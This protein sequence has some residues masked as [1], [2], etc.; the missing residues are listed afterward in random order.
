MATVNE[1]I[2]EWIK[3]L[4]KQWLTPVNQKWGFGLRF[5]CAFA[6][7]LSVFT[8]VA[9]FRLADTMGILVTDI[10]LTGDFYYFSIIFIALLIS[11]SV[12]IWF[13]WL[14]SWRDFGYGPARLYL[15]GIV[16]P[17]LAWLIISR[18]FVLA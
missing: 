3:V 15:S 18:V 2:A 4:R 8:L 9:F 6:G 13:A 12:A 11:V 14:V 10:L 7:S 16:L 1:E 17:T 5:L